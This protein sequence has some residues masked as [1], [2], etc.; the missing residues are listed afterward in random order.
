MEC[1]QCF[2]DRFIRYTPSSI[3][4]GVS[5]NKNG[6]SLP[7]LIER[8]HLFVQTQQP[9]LLF[10]DCIPPRCQP[11][12]LKEW[13]LR[14]TRKVQQAMTAI[15]IASEE[16][17]PCKEDRPLVSYLASTGRSGRPG[18]FAGL[19]FYDEAIHDSPGRGDPPAML[20]PT[21]PSAP[22]SSHPDV[23]AVASRPHL[24]FI[25][26]E[27][28]CNLVASH[29]EAP[30]LIPSHF[31]FLPAE[32][33]DCGS[34]SLNSPSCRPVSARSPSPT[35]SPFPCTP[36]H[37]R[38]PTCPTPAPRRG[39]LADTCVEAARCELAGDYVRARQLYNYLSDKMTNKAYAMTA[40]LNKAKRKRD[41]GGSFEE[42]R[43]C[44]ESIALRP[45]R[46]HAR[47]E[48]VMSKANTRYATIEASAMR[49]LVLRIR[50]R[51]DDSGMILSLA[52]WACYAV[53][54]VNQRGVNRDKEKLQTLPQIISRLCGFL[55]REATMKKI[56]QI[57]A[58]RIFFAP[59][60]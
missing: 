49:E 22:A 51:R 40:A 35:Q 38:H 19:Q 12:L 57:M 52:D 58:H 43:S 59:Q 31:P 11:P 30:S 29:D 41:F 48:E 50:A 60:S 25:L 17:G 34:S 53:Y 56:P 9:L 44:V 6:I 2:S 37:T 14:F 21:P 20:L 26:L 7:D 54:H 23:T 42:G 27:G 55:M 32:V 16:S 15:W 13:S 1:V 39:T 36:V 33:V 28:V 46:L 5:I 45:Q 18:V 3:S 8:I 4:V 24:P 10:Q 47:Y